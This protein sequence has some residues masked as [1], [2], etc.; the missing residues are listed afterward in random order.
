M[1]EQAL[2]PLDEFVTA[3]LPTEA[4][5]LRD[6]AILD[7]VPEPLFLLMLEKARPDVVAERDAIKKLLAEGYSER[8]IAAVT[9][10]NHTAIRRRLNL[11]N[12]IPALVELYRV[13]G[14]TANVLESCAKLPEPIQL[15]LAKKAAET[16][17]LSAKDVADA[18]K[19]RAQAAVD[20]LPGDIFS[21]E[22]PA[23]DW[24]S[25][26]RAGLAQAAARIPAHEIH[27]RERFQQLLEELEA[28][29]A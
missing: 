17:R 12:A 16:G 1:S 7:G 15:E 6:M 22:P 20:G 25:E 29:K 9:P 4:D 21:P 26:V 19:S 8:D 10:F 18:R 5:D 28:I 13:G 24:R 23:S 27:L 2:L 3:A 14:A 11:D